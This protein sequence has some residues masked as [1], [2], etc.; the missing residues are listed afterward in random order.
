MR[1]KK[2]GVRNCYRI[3][4]SSFLVPVPRSRLLHY[5]EVRRRVQI[6]S[7]GII[8]NAIERAFGFDAEQLVDATERQVVTPTRLIAA[9]IGE[10]RLEAHALN[11]HGRLPSGRHPASTP[12]VHRFAGDLPIAVMHKCKWLANAQS[13]PRALRRDERVT[14]EATCAR[15]RTHCG[16]P[17]ARIAQQR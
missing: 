5:A 14:N 2:R 4:H 17:R 16:E 3:P 13:W 1:K 10:P 7:P 11:A 8:Q 12:L 15:S 6:V 9:W